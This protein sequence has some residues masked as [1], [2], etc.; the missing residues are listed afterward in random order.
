MFDNLFRKDDIYS[1]PAK[2]IEMQVRAREEQRYMQGE[3]K[4]M[5]YSSY[6]GSRIRL[7]G[8]FDAPCL[9]GKKACLPQPANL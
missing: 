9:V 2:E 7:G 5:L 1:R 6:N 4:E 3:D 8:V